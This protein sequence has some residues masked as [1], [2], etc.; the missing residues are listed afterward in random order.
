MMETP[1]KKRHGQRGMAVLGVVL[2]LVFI[3]ALVLPALLYFMGTASKAG[4]IVERK[5]KEYY[6]A[7]SGV[8]AGLWRIKTD[9]KLPAWL[10][11]INWGESVYGHASENYTLSSADPINDNSVVYQI[12]SKWVLDG[13]ETPNGTQ[14]RNPATYILVADNYL[15][16]GSVSGR[17]KFEIALYFDSSITRVKVSRIACWLPAGYQLVPNSSNLGNASSGT[18]YHCDPTTYSYRSGTAVSWDYATPIYYDQLPQDGTKYVVT[19]EFTPNQVPQ[20]IFCWI[21]TNDTGSNY[22]AWNTDLKVFQVTSTATSAT[23]QATTVTAYNTKKE[24]QKYGALIEGD[25]VATGNTLMRDTN[26]ADQQHRDR[27]YKESSQTIT[28]IPANAQV[29]MV[30][31]YWTGWKCKPWNAWNYTALQQAAWPSTYQVNK[32]KFNLSVN[33]VNCPITPVTATVTQVV[34]NGTSSSDHGWAYSC[35]ANIT[36]TVKNFYTSQG[37]SYVG[38]GTY[39]VGHNNASSSS[40]GRTSMYT[41]IPGAAYPYSSEIYSSPRYIQYPLGSPRDGNQTDTNNSSNR[42]WS[43]SEDE[44]AY[45]A[46]SVVIVYTSP[47]TKGHQLYIFDTLKYN[48]YDALPDFTISGFLTPDLPGEPDAAKI[49]C[50]VGEGD[51]IYDGDSIAVNGV[52]L[53][54]DADNPSNNI[55]NSQS[56]IEGN[57]VKGIDIDT[58]NISNTIIQPGDDSATVTLH[59]DV[60]AWNLVYMIL[61]FRSK[62]TTGGIFIYDLN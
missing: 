54:G 42:E 51:V 15:G 7:N 5:T 50:F 48:Q 17:G 43:G 62:L 55:W 41:M 52:T 56:R 4:Q 14:Q 11:A 39:T 26:N 36:S 35:Y 8:D 2:I 49:T 47:S 33:G 58:F 20:G 27:L 46:W 21:K 1:K 53:P 24:F 3:G 18:V 38:N 59:T 13:L 6:A 57:P 10:D 44:W 22:L 31:L 29:Q 19:F 23:G 60:D 40:T 34:P 9:G 32:V 12:G 61:S 16:T 28:T 30:T 37:V 25:Y 45:A